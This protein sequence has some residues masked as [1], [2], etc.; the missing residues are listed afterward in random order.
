MLKNILTVLRKLASAAMNFLI[1][2]FETIAVPMS[3]A[4][5]GT[6]MFTMYT[7][8]SNIFNG[9]VCLLAALKVNPK[10]VYEASR[11]RRLEYKPEP[12]EAYRPPRI[13]VKETARRPRPQIDIPL[14]GEDEAARRGRETVE[15]E[16]PRRAGFFKRESNVPKPHEVL[17]GAPAQPA[18]DRRFFL[19]KAL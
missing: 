12:E 16:K 2:Y 9:A 18:A 19:V 10:K 17:S 14:D 8:L 3:W 5:G 1:V 4:M 15:E 11:A 13:T 6:I 7:E